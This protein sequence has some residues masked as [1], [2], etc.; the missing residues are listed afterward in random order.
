[1]LETKKSATSGFRSGVHE[2]GVP[3]RGVPA[4][5]LAPRF[6]SQVVDMANPEYYHGA[7]KQRDGTWVT[8]KYGDAGGVD[9]ESAADSKVWERRPLYCCPVPGMADWCTPAATPAAPAS[10]AG[11][12]MLCALHVRPACNQH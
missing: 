3:V 7:V 1:M 5:H 9:L 11:E 10:A 4:E 8:T 2:G 6:A 12:G